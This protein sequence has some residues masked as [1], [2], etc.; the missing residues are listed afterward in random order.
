MRMWVRFAVWFSCFLSVLTG[1]SLALALVLLGPA[2]AGPSASVSCGDTITT[3]TTLTSDL[4]D[5]VGNGLVIG[6]DNI[7]LDCSGHLI[8]GDDS[9]TDSG[10]YLSGRSGVTVQNCTVT[11]FHDGIYLYYSSNNTLTGNT[12]ASNTETGI[13]L[14]VFANNNDIENNTVRNN[15]ILGISMVSNSDNN[16]LNSNVA[17][18]SR[19]DI[20][21]TGS[22]SGDNNTC[23]A[24]SNWD[25]DGTTG[26]TF[27][28]ILPVG[29]IAELP[30]ASDSSPP[31]YTTVA[32]LAAAALLALTAGAWCTRR[33]WLT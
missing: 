24:T 1:L 7:T 26:C 33:R 17:C 10:V 12:S 4:T 22:N 25:D 30:A 16:T 23:D 13:H 9:G 21:N 15:N 5:C 28:C 2:A 19:I 31:N 18:S 8:G 32:A 6:A 27:S 29:G 20:A 3:D 11:G 14:G